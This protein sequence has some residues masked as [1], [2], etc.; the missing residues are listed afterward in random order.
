MPKDLQ[1]SLLE[2][3]AHINSEDYDRIPGDFINLGFSPPDKLKQLENSGISEG[4]AFAFRQLNK[5]GGPS[6]IRER[7]KA[8][9]SSRYGE[10]L[11]DEEIR[12]KARAE[13]IS[14]FEDQLKKEGVDVQG[15]T[16]VM[17]EMSR[18]NRELFKLPPYVLYVSRAFS[19]LEGIGLSVDENYSIL[20]ECFPYLAQR[21]FEDDSPRARQALRAM[22]FGTEGSL[23]AAKVVEMVNNY[24]TFSASTSIVTND[25]QQASARGMEAISTLLL[26]PAGSP[27]QD[28]LAEGAAR[29]VDSL[30]REGYSR[31][32]K[33]A[34][35]NA[36][37]S[38]LSAPKALH[39]ALSGASE[40]VRGATE[41]LLPQQFHG[42][43]RSATDAML[44][45]LLVPYEIGRVVDELMQ[46]EEEDERV[47]ESLNTLIRAL[48]PP[49]ANPAPNAGSN[50]ITGLDF[51]TGT[52]LSSILSS[53]PRP[54][55]P[56]LS[57]KGL[58]ELSMA[59][60]KAGPI[61][62][63]VTKKLGRSLLL[64]AA[65]RLD[66]TTHAHGGSGHAEAGTGLRFLEGDK[67]GNTIGD[68]LGLGL[69]LD[70]QGQPQER[71]MLPEVVVGD[72]SAASNP[73]PNLT[74]R[75]ARA[76]ASVSKTLAERLR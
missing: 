62:A 65:E 16:A 36:V 20:S 60:G 10:G 43:L 24:R 41:R 46:K 54:N 68:R 58:E 40:T 56:P 44:G 32:R 29:G 39:S 17:E 12:A 6:K 59:L 13:M 53:L 5:G 14:R 48:T 22:L 55:L 9:F 2:F 15:V 23:D 27:I 8:E 19:T 11:S 28:L 76:A 72:S 47:V 63:N 51:N 42:Q 35:G 67:H 7:M 64:R 75:A 25:E 18:R 37:F 3:I 26:D 71:S 70:E 31:G 4:L 21:L 61:G 52:P 74:V 34:V 30:L 73:N 69:L 50:P 49:S 57:Q 66:R 33:T 38:A 1:Y 45:P